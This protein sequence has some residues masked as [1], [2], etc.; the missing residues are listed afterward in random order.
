MD[1]AFRRIAEG[2]EDAVK[3]AGCEHKGASVERRGFARVAWRCPD[4][5]G[6]FNRDPRKEPEHG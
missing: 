5:G 6:R 1:S 3:I 2:L 4:C